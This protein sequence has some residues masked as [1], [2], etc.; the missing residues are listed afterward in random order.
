MNIIKYIREAV[1]DSRLLLTDYEG[2]TIS[3]GTKLLSPQS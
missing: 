2:A 1:W 3:S